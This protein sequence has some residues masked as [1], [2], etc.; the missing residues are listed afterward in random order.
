VRYHSEELV[1]RL[2]GFYGGRAL[3]FGTHQSLA[4]LLGELTRGYFSEHQHHSDRLTR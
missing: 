1:L 4:L 3:E 2:V